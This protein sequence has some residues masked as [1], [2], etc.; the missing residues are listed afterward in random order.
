MPAVEP[1][2]RPFPFACC[3]GLG[4]HTHGRGRAGPAYVV[5][6]GPHHLELVDQLLMQRTHFWMHELLV[7]CQPDSKDVDL[8][9]DRQAALS[10]GGSPWEL[11]PPCGA[12]PFPPAPGFQAQHNIPAPA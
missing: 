8:L 2:P 7:D 9:G 3:T 4:D 11:R 6:T 10:A 5:E 12:W 1:A